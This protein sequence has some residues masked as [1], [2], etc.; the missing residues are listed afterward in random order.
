MAVSE[1]SCFQFL[2]K[3]PQILCA[4]RLY[5][6]AYTLSSIF[7][8]SP[9]KWFYWNFCVKMVRNAYFWPLC[10][11][12]MTKWP[13]IWYSDTLAACDLACCLRFFMWTLNML[14]LCKFW[15][16]M[17]KKHI[18]GS[19][20]L[21]PIYKRTKFGT[22]IGWDYALRHVISIFWCGPLNAFNSG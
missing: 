2:T 21:V 9:Q 1:A 11:H 13:Q 6:Y 4:G 10:P 14:E 8:K 3:L 19:C 22:M 16:K 20:T 17:T 7:D 15:V 5:Q 18:S 12:I